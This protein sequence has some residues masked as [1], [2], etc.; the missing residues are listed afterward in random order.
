MPADGDTLPLPRSAAARLPAGVA[1]V[2]LAVTPACRL[3][4]PD[5][6]YDLLEAELRTREREVAE[7]RGEVARQGQLNQ[8][9]GQPSAARPDLPP[10]DPPG[11]FS[12]SG[13]VLTLPLKDVILAAGTGG[14]DEDNLPG[15][16]YLQVVIAPRDDDGTVVKVPLRG[17][18]RAYEVSTEGLKT[19]L[20]Q[21]DVT[22]DQMRKSWKS[23]L[24]SS[25]YFVPLQ[26]DRPP[27]ADRLR[28]VARVATADGREFEADKEVRVR[29]LT[30]PRP[31]P[32]PGPAWDTLPPPAATGPPPPLPPGTEE[33]PPPA[34]LRYRP[35]NDR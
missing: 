24:L 2:L 10:C 32:A 16:E 20:G 7:L 8:L 5:R 3:T 31:A 33:L 12:S 15:D 26:W 30:P 28:L 29:P 11:V 23:G 19:P 1:C 21:W 13:R 14:V 27:A 4:G 34:R 9:F 25:G 17:T 18:V 6:R 35:T 22:P